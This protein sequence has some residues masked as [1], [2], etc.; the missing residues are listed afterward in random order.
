MSADLLQIDG[1]FGEGGG[2][3]LRS[4]LALSMCTGRGFVIRNIPSFIFRRMKI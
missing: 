3:I 2:Q 4:S 1:T